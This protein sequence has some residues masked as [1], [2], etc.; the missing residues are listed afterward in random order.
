[1]GNLGTLFYPS[2]VI[3]HLFPLHAPLTLWFLDAPFGRFAKKTSSWNVNGEGMPSM[4]LGSCAEVLMIRQSR[5]VL[6]GAR[7][8][9]FVV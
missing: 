1:M 7:L 9:R 8:G 5:L 6:D 3:Y 4:G 2:L